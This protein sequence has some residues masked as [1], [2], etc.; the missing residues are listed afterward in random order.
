[1]RAGADISHWNTVQSWVN[2]GKAL[3]F[4]II[5]ATEGTRFTDPAFASRW[6]TLGELRKAGSIKKRGAYHFARFNVGPEAQVDHFVDV[7]ERRG[8]G[9]DA[10]LVLDVETVDGQ[11]GK[12]VRN[13]FDDM[14]SRLR[15]RRP[16]N[17]LWT[18]TGNWWLKAVGLTSATATPNM[19]RTGL[20]LAV[21]DDDPKAR[22]K[23]QAGWSSVI[24][25]QWTD[26][27]LIPGVNAGVRSVDANS[28]FGTAF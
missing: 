21:Y 20:W 14:V 15:A 13:R 26:H 5:K 16:K 10:I 18:Y 23:P 9:P 24:A 11:S 1:M 7:V 22:P 17:M 19:H 4:V 6:K 25:K 2:V 12:T 3:D 28:Y 8:L 27:G